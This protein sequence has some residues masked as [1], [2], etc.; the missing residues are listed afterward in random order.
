MISIA[1][2]RAALQGNW[3]AFDKWGSP[4]PYEVPKDVGPATLSVSPVTD[5]LKRLDSEG[6]VASE[7]DKRGLWSVDAIVLN[8]VV[9][10]RLPGE[11]YTAEQLIDE[12]RAI[13]FGWQISP[14]SAP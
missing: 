14:T 2:L 9:L 10:D 7:V 13:G 1:G 6:N 3:V 11:T 8:I 4:V 12:V 5:A